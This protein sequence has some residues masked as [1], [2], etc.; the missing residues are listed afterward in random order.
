MPRFVSPVFVFIVIFGFGVNLNIKSCSLFSNRSLSFSIS[1]I[2]LSIFIKSKS[3][4]MDLCIAS[5]IFSF[6]LRL[7]HILKRKI[8]NFVLIKIE[9][10]PV[11]VN[12][13]KFLY[14]LAYNLNK[15]HIVKLIFFSSERKSPS[16]WRKECWPSTAVFSPN[17]TSVFADF[18][19]LSLFSN[20][21]IKKTK[22]KEFI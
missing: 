17:S 1:W 5:Y 6:W 7:R 2:L 11:I 18:S 22:K 13:T 21:I 8:L 19:F 14:K 15:S 10:I 16:L 4:S 3:S 12:L 9:C 20:W